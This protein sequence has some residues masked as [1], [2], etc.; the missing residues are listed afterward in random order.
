MYGHAHNEGFIDNNTYV[1]KIDPETGKEYIDHVL[2]VN[3]NLIENFKVQEV[4]ELETAEKEPQYFVNTI[5]W[6]TLW[7]QAIEM[8][9]SGMGTRVVA[10]RLGLNWGTFRKRVRKHYGTQ[11]PKEGEHYPK[12]LEENSLHPL[13]TEEL[14]EKIKQ[15]FFETEP[16][17]IIP[18]LDPIVEPLSLTQ[19]QANFKDM[20]LQL[21]DYISLC[22]LSPTVK[23]E[24]IKTISKME[25]PK[26]VVNE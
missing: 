3:G 1:K 12:Q 6:E 4:E 24:A 14:E 20:Q 22:Q 10:E 17:L 5:D 23:L 21:I 11:N 19:D 25:Y 16:V 26:E 2:D 9:E 8:I 13:F 15:V 7:P 18:P